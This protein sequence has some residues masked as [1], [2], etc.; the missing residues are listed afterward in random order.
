MIGNRNL[1]VNLDQYV[2]TKVN[3][4]ANKIMVVNGKV[5]VNTLTTQGEPKTIYEVY[6]V[7]GLEHNLIS[8][9]QLR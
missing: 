6:Y 8:V 1:V 5:V 9:G 4:G 2:K 7:A 3:L